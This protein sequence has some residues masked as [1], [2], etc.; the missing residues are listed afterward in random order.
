MSQGWCYL[1]INQRRGVLS[2]AQGQ[3][4]LMLIQRSGLLASLP[5][6][7]GVIMLP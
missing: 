1:A 6:Q 5:I 2:E 7:Q 4:L 3:K